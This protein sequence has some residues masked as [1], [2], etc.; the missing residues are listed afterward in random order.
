MNKFERLFVNTQ[1]KASDK[2]I[3]IRREKPENMKPEEPTWKDVVQETLEKLGGIGHLKE[4]NKQ[5]KRHEKA[6]SR[7]WP[8]TVRRT[9][10]QYSIFYQEKPGSGIW[11]LR[12]GEPAVEFDPHKYPHP[13]HEDAQGMLLE[14]GKIYGYETSVPPY[15]RKKKFLDRTLEE[16]A[17]LEQVPPFT[18]SDIV[19]IAR[20][21]DVMWFKGDPERWMPKFAFEVEHTTDIT[22][23]LTRLNDLYQTV[24]QVKPFI[25]L[26]ED[27]IKK[28]EIEISRG[29]FSKIKDVCQVKTYNS[30]IDLYNLAVEHHSIK[31]EFLGE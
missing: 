28:F 25:V 18:Y 8:A 24:V 10:Q 22:K 30:L 19:R 21:I 13:K 14:L 5:I 17:T 7:T 23:G 31:S 11:L 26:P 3:K 12:K 29:T 6:K 20:T 1:I 4:I 16:I 15:D 9:L 27:K 2:N